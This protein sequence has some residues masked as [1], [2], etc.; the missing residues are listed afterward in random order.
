MTSTGNSPVL[1]IVA[2]Q[3]STDSRANC[4]IDCLKD[5]WSDERPKSMSGVFSDQ[6]LENGT[7]P[8]GG[9]RQI[10]RQHACVAD[11][12]HEVGVPVPARDHVDV[13]MIE[14]A[15]AGRA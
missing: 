11:D 1:S 9:L 15:R 7:E 12:A 4:S 3:G 2:A 13:Q 14:H 6:P 10:F 8:L 5:C